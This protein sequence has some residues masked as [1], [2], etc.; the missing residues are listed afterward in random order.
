LRGRVIEALRVGQNDVKSAENWY[1][2]FMPQPQ[3]GVTREAGPITE[4]ATFQVQ[5]LST[6]YLVKIS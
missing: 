1:E 6:A 4:D 5:S 2:D 3:P